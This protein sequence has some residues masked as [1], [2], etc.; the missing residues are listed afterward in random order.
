VIRFSILRCDL[1]MASAGLVQAKG[2]GDLF[3][4]LR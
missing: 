3:H 2:V 1:M 4:D